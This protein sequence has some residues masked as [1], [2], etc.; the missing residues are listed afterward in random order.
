MAPHVPPTGHRR[1]RSRTDG[2]FRPNAVCRRSAVAV[3][4]GLGLLASA[5][6][7]SSDDPGPGD[8]APQD[9]DR[10]TSTDPST[11]ETLQATIDGDGDGADGDADGDGD[12]GDLTSSAG[13]ATPPGFCDGA[14]S[15][16]IRFQPGGTSAVLD[17]P[18]SADQRDLFQLAVGDDQILTVVLDSS[19]A[20]AGATVVP[21][22]G[23]ESDVFT[24]QII[25]PTEAGSYAICVTAGPTG[26]DYRLT[27]TVID[28][29]IPTRVDAP[30]C[31]DTVNDRGAIRFAAGS[32]SGTVDGAV[33]SAERD[34]YT[35][36][37]GE[38]Q[39][40]DLF[41]VSAEANAVFDLRSPSGE[42]LVDEVSDFRIPLPEDGVYEICVGSVRGNATYVLDVSIA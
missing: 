37:A 10:T 18:A 4:A 27:V 20:E 8:A 39:D 15:T 19:D 22:A 3:V 1:R 14:A 25:A 16:E 17:N 38:G 36:E 24:E 35:I 26:A 11:P 21:P 12:G 34:L 2:P 30:W 41:L 13:T 33:L 7:L 28:D 31:G 40:I 29:N 42:I 23:A 5:C 9:T 32:F 6:S